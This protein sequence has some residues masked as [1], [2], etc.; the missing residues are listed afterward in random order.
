MRRRTGKKI[1]IWVILLCSVSG[2]AGKAEIPARP[3]PVDLQCEHR[4]NPLGIDTEKPR[5]G[6]KLFDPAATRGQ[7]Q[8]AYQVLVASDSSR[9]AQGEGDVW[10][11]GKVMSAQSVL[12]PFGGRELASGH[13]YFWKV[14]VFDK[15][16]NPSE[17][18]EPAGFVTG[19][20][21]E[22]DWQHSEI[23]LCL[24][25][26]ACASRN[27]EWQKT[28]ADFRT[29]PVGIRP[30]PLWFW[31]NTRVEPEELKRQMAGYKEAGYGGLSILPF[32]KNFKPEYLSDAYFD[33]YRVCVEEAAGLGLTLWLYDEYG[34]PSGTA[35]DINGDGIGR[36]RQRYPEHT[37]KR[38]DKTEYRPVTGVPFE[39]V[40]PEGVVMAAVAMDTVSLERMDLTAR[41]DRGKL[42]WTPPGNHWKVM[43]FTCVDAGRTI[44]D[45]MSPEAV[46]L[47]I[48]MTH[49]EY[50]KRFGKYFGTTVVGTFFDEPTLYYA[51]G[52]AWTPEFNRKFEEKYGFSP[53]LYYPALWYDIGSETSEARN[54]LFGFRSELYAAGYPKLV[55]DWSRAHGVMAT[56]HQDNE[57]VVNCTGTAGDLMKCFK[58]QDIP[59]I[60]KIGGNRP[61]ERF[62]KI[63][64]SAAWNW[65]HSLVMSETYGA[66]GNI[67]W[68]EIFG[69]AMDQYVKGINLLIPHAVWYNTDRVTFL[70]ELSLRNPLYADSLRVFTDYLARLNAFMQN[71]SRWVGDMAVLYPVHTMQSGHYMDGPLGHYRGG[72]ELPELNYVDVG[73]SLADSLGYDF[74][75]LHPEV[76]DDRC[77]VEKGTLFLDNGV[78]YNSFHTLIV[79]ASTTVSL[80]NLEKMQALAQAGGHVIFVSQMPSKATRASDDEK[81]VALVKLLSEHENVI[82]VDKPDPA[83]LKT[84]LSKIPS[85]LTFTGKTSLRNIHK[86][87]H[88]K[89]FW[90]FANPELTPKSAEIE[91]TGEYR[92]ECWNPHNGNTEDTL[93]AIRQNGKTRFRID[94]DGCK[95][96]FVVEK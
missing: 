64:S 32:G 6:W 83:S 13:N 57:E 69:I 20:L 90:F 79:P 12:V 84:A 78:Q 3:V 9:L 49:D 86:V 81:A 70:P 66:M 1:F 44:V 72:V 74:M 53:A 71:E 37:Y 68:N 14:R 21:H 19:L 43:I 47:Y 82:F 5:F 15:D 65:N 18:S 76:L 28:A 80:S 42:T 56:G 38:L 60:D 94:L 87:L 58:Y 89:N 55:S 63:V 30:N 92:L 25:L 73:V 54:F 59:G 2:S 17:W 93:P 52:R 22:S 11:S 35:G 88:G 51:D 75:F 67:G 46:R 95:S 39:Q 24:A 16:G 29:V 26:S 36:F 61:A 8:T 45:Y 7:K 96:V 50:Y 85:S 10:D 48:G 23:L 91:V 33:M 62:Y 4:T 41:V 40:L 31:N 77:R 34:F 27:A